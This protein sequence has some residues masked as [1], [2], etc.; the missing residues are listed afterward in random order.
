MHNEKHD[1]SWPC[2]RHEWCKKTIKHTDP[3]D[4]TKSRGRF[5]QGST[6]L[7]PDADCPHK[8]DNDALDSSDDVS[9]CVKD[10]MPTKPVS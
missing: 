4:T 1:L 6:P 8:A 2:L 5:G 9:E 10:K 3:G 7:N